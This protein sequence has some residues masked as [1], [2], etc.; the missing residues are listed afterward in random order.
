VG[1]AGRRR[2][3]DAA[4]ARDREREEQRD[5]RDEEREEALGDGAVRTMSME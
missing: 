3:S 2:V 4:A 5:D 1:V